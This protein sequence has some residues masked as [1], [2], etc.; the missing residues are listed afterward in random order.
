MH[1][2]PRLLQSETASSHLNAVCRAN[3]AI[4]LASGHGF[5]RRDNFRSR[6]PTLTAKQ[7][8]SGINGNAAESMAF[9][10]KTLRS[11]VHTLSLL[12]MTSPMFVVLGETG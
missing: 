10:G 12:E 1:T 11:T 5:S 8:W 3:K 6:L 7:T 2:R 9:R 4:S